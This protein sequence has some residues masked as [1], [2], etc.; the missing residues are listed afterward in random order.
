M[1]R[2]M[3]VVGYQGR[4]IT[5][6]KGDWDDDEVTGIRDFSIAPGDVVILPPDDVEVEFVTID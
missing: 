1:S 3:Q 2:T 5:V 6:L 4:L